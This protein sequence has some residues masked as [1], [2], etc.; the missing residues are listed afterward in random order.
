MMAWHILEPRV[1]RRVSSSKHA[2]CS[3]SDVSWARRSL[4]SLSSWRVIFCARPSVSSRTDVSTA[5]FSAFAW[6]THSS[7]SLTARAVR[8]SP[9]LGHLSLQCG[10]ICTILGL[11]LREQGTK[12]A[13]KYARRKSLRTRVEFL[14]SFSELPRTD[15]ECCGGLKPVCRGA[16]SPR[17]Q[18][19][20]TQTPPHSPPTSN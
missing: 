1:Y 16:T 19:M 15:E 14:P 3:L 9:C 8:S 11:E 10:N 5:G 6:D 18:P 12:K 17:R 20:N 7:A 2:R 13:S 4:V